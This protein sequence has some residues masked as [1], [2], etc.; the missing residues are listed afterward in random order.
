M[1]EFGENLKRVREEKGITQQT[2]ADYLY[3]TRQ[4]VSRWE[5]GSRYPDIMTAKKISQYLE[6]SLDD[7]LSDDD[8][9]LYVEKSEILDTPISKRVQIVLMTLAF[10]CAMFHSIFYLCNTFI[11]GLL[12]YSS[13]EITLKSVLLTLILGYGVY[14]AIRDK[15]NPKLTAVFYT[16]YL[17]ANLVVTIMGMISSYGTFSLQSYIGAILYDIVF[18]V[19]G[20][21][22]YCGDRVKSPIPLY[23]M[24]GIDTLCS[25]ISFMMN[26]S[27]APFE[28]FR[29][30]FVLQILGFM[31]EIFFF[32][33]VVFMTYTLDKKRRRA[34]R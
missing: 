5:G 25:I 10:M 9:K 20:I 27:G 26:I 7:L 18:V 30:I 13:H 2:L 19:I 32:V 23:I 22:F 28:I 33:L 16:Y 6:V 15:L 1:A 29:D 11:H 4:A 3:V 34:A 24:I 21:R 8:M 14:A 12:M 31:Q 17:A